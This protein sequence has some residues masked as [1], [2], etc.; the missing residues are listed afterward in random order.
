MLTNA[1]ICATRTVILSMAFALIPLFGTTAEA[2]PV[3]EAFNYQGVLNFEGSPFSG[4]VD[5]RFEL[6]DDSIGGLQIGPT[7]QFDVMS[8]SDGVFAVDLDFGMGIFMGDG[9]WLSVAVRSPAW[10]GMGMEPAFT[11]LMPRQPI[12]PTPYALFAL[13]GNQGPIGMQ[14]TQGDPGIQGIQGDPGLQGMMGMEGIQGVPGIQGFPGMDGAEGMPGA[15]G[16]DGDTHWSFD[17]TDTWFTGGFVGIGTSDPAIPLTIRGPGATS[18]SGITM[19]SFA[20]VSAMEFQTEDSMGTLT[21]RMVMRGGSDTTDV[22]FLTGSNGAEVLMMH[23]E[24]SNGKIGIGRTPSVNLDVGSGVDRFGVDLSTAGTVKTGSLATGS[25]NL[26]LSSVANIDI[27]FDSD[28]NITNGLIRIKHE[29]G[30]ELMRIREDGRIGIGT[31]IPANAALHVTNSNKPTTIIARN[32][33]D[34]GVVIDARSLAA[35]GDSIV[36]FFQLNGN[37]GTA[38]RGEA[39]SN[40]GLTYGVRGISDSAAT[41]AAGVRGE[42]T[43]GGT[44]FGVYGS[45]VGAANAYGVFS[46][47]RLGSSGTKSFMIDH[48]LDPENKVLYHYSAESPDVLNIYTG[49]AI[50]DANGEAFFFID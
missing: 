8:I 36:G 30:L 27:V 32:G 13:S 12:K 43:R 28:A 20:G 14:G 6:Y 31:T 39:V 47:G 37:Q 40:S 44:N 26:E 15:D 42:A 49:N 1:T 23:L 34:G 10:D 29:N 16:L 46:N 2:A 48:P 38:L 24:G 22:E 5:L 18:D 4:D 3:D 45:A 7:L 50:L 25:G 17:G 11:T 41:N 33:N 35:T 19:N 9:R 21:T